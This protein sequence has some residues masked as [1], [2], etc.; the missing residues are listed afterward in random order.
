MSMIQWNNLFRGI[1]HID[2]HILTEIEDNDSERDEDYQIIEIKKPR[3]S[4][5]S[6]QQKQRYA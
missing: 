1:I 3:V 4:Y 6:V 5:Q 2:E